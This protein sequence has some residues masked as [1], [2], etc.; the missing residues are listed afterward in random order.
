[1]LTALQNEGLEAQLFTFAAGEWNK[2]REIWATLTDDLLRAGIARD[3]AIVALGG[4]VAG[5]LAGFV[6]ATYM[7]GL[8]VVQIPTTLLAMVDSSV[9]GKTGLDTPGA[10]NLL[11][12]FHQPSL[13]LVDPMV[14]N[15]LP[16]SQM[17]AGL[18]ETLK[19]GLIL[20]A[21]YFERI[22]D[23]LD[24]I[25]ARDP[26][27]L[28]DL[29]SRSVTIKA[30]VVSQDTYESDY[31]RVLNFGH[32]VGHVL[33]T[34]SGYGWL[35]GEAVAVG[36]VLEAALGEAVGVTK[37]GVAERVREVLEA[38]RLPV[39]MDSDV[40]PTRF[41]E[42]MEA[43]KK[44]EGGRGRYTLLAGIGRVAPCSDEGWTHEIEEEVVRSVLFD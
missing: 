12:A 8:P 31:R 35:H 42:I 15:T 18:A 37:A 11:G 38:A 29:I 7:R 41:F 33:E 6:A 4:G 24:R 21:E 25:F 26:E 19:H 23:G 40:E 17:A 22:A 39:E 30:G 10:K 16:D 1:M 2:T 5:D 3:S 34:L 36:M 14:L 43:D 44:R 27:M 32:S 13:V 20:D 9:G 28:D